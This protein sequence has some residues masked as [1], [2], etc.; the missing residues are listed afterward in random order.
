M[1]AEG[2]CREG[3]ERVGKGHTFTGN[4]ITYKIGV[5]RAT[6]SHRL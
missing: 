6:V 3:K 2:E 4:E 5:Q 1:L